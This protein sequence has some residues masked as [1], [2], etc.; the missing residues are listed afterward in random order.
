MIVTSCDSMWLQIVFTAHLPQPKISVV[1]QSFET[2][3][4][5]VG[6]I[7]VIHWRTTWCQ[8]RSDLASYS[9][10]L[11]QIWW[12]WLY[13]NYLSFLTTIQNY[14][15]RHVICCI[16][17][18]FQIICVIIYSHFKSLLWY[19]LFI[20][21]ILICRAPFRKTY[22]STFG[23]LQQRFRLI[24][25]NRWVSVC[26]GVK[27]IVKTKFLTFFPLKIR[28]NLCVISGIF[29]LHLKKIIDQLKPRSDR[30]FLVLSNVTN[31]QCIAWKCA[32]C[33]SALVPRLCIALTKLLQLSIFKDTNT[34]RFI[35]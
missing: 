19:L 32:L 7:N 20:C 15:Y 30:T 6:E 5:S 33:F 26:V 29:W 8:C 28:S 35:I 23:K 10:L 13:L 16:L 17:L 9:A 12:T 22:R 3:G 1:T 2:V 34:T 31:N 14:F 11:S 27:C 24:T 18:L 21:F 4:S 25:S